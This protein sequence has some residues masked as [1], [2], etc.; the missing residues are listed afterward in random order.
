MEMLIHLHI[1]DVRVKGD[2]LSK[3]SGKLPEHHKYECPPTPSHSL[4][5]LI[6]HISSLAYLTSLI[7]KDNS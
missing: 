2:N 1:F 6:G 4:N 3:V 5:Y 7:Y